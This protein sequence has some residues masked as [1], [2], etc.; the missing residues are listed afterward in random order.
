MIRQYVNSV[1]DGPELTTAV[2]ID[3]QQLIIG[4]M[5]LD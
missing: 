1:C 2:T 3:A 4:M 5:K